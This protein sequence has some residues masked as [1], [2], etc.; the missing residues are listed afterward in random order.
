MKYKWEIFWAIVVLCLLGTFALGQIAYTST[1]PSSST[2]FIEVTKTVFLCLG[3]LGVILPLYIHATN[4]IEARASSIIE[5]TFDLLAKWDDSHLFAARKYTREIKKKQSDISENQL[6]SDIKENQDLEQ[7]IIL[8]GNYFEHVRFSIKT[9]RIDVAVFK[10]SLGVTILGIT[11]RFK[12]F[13]KEQGQHVLKD[14]EE[15][16]SLLK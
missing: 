10:E 13:Y 14:I 12:P 5:N 3:G 2:T 4:A 15:L 11:S 9:K 6:L 8:I 7:S 1:P 16:E